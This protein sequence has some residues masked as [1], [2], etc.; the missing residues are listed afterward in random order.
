M[1]TANTDPFLI[2]THQGT[3]KNVPYYTNKTSQ[4]SGGSLSPASLA[5]SSKVDISLFSASDIAKLTLDN[6]KNFF[7][8]DKN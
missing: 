8:H 4:Q 7:V 5:F 6:I 1:A 2:I 3:L